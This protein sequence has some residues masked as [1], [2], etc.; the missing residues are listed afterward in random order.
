MVRAR[1]Q[2]A[3]LKQ[4]LEMLQVVTPQGGI[5]GAEGGL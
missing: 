5:Y 3:S 4:F 1:R 2:G